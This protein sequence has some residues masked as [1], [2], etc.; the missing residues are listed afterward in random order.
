MQYPPSQLIL[1]VSTSGSIGILVAASLHDI[2]ART[3]PNRIVLALAVVGV[4]AHTVDGALLPAVLAGGIVFC[5]GAFFW[6]C[7]WMGGGDV[8]LLAAVVLAVPTSDV[9]HLIASVALAGGVLGLLYLAARVVVPAPRSARPHALWARALRA[10]CWRIR[11]GGPLPYACAIAAGAI[12][13]I[14]H[15]GAP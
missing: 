15:G 5:V 7:G 3:I 1:S 10:E 12:F 13:T 4:F 11:R 8:K 9:F 14:V 6:R 2:A